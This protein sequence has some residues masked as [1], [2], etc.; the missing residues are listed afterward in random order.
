MENATFEMRIDT[1]GGGGCRDA[2]K[3]DMNRRSTLTGSRRVAEA[4]QSSALR[5]VAG[6]LDLTSPTCRGG[7]GP[8]V[9]RGQGEHPI[10][11]LQSS[12]PGV[13]KDPRNELGTCFIEPITQ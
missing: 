3:I 12:C 7:S 5:P 9:G 6:E 1:S 8:D 2:A 11:E 10:T 4:C 13:Q